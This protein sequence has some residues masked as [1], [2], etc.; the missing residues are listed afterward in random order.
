[1]SHQVVV[2]PYNIKYIPKATIRL[3]ASPHIYGFD[4]DHTLIKP[5]TPNAIFAKTADDWKYI[6]FTKGKLTIEKVY[7][8][9]EEDPLAIIVIFTN[10]GGV[11]TVPSSSK[12]YYKFNMK[13]KHILENIK[14]H[15]LGDELLKRLWIYSSTKKPA[16]VKKSSGTSAKKGKVMKLT[17]LKGV[18][19]SNS[20]GD[21]KRIVHPDDKFTEMRKPEIG[22]YSEFMQDISK[23]MDVLIDK[24]CW[25]WYCGDAAGRKSDFSDSDSAFA[26]KIGIPFK[27]PEDVF[28]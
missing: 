24:K 23:K 22:M 4:L 3:S 25:Q 8:I 26:D 15:E 21:S 13:I 16:S 17:D 5:K 1:M 18:N 7:K 14:S 9:I 12:S 19:F 2:N 11:L 10:Q 27:L 20:D 28:R 6:E